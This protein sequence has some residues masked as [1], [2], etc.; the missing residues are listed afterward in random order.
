MGTNERTP[1]CSKWGWC[2]IKQRKQ[3]KIRTVNIRRMPTSH[4]HVPQLFLV[5]WQDPNICL[6]FGFLLSLLSSLPEQFSF[7]LINTKSR[8]L[9]G[10]SWFVCL[11]IPQNS[12]SRTDS[13]LCIYHLVVL[14]NF[15]LLHISQRITFP[16]MSCLVLYFFVL[17]WC[18][19]LLCDKLFHLFLYITS[20]EYY[21][22]LLS[23][24]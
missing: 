21:R 5:S 19:R 18:F 15:N 11:K 9:A 16:I 13:G 6:S 7:L 22:F 2:A 3:T 4:S 14:T 20:V 12:F 10:Y 24:N 17:V 8:L 1:N 23:H